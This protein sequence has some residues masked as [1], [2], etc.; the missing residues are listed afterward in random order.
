MELNEQ[1]LIA[2]I[3]SGIANTLV[4]KREFL[5]AMTVE[6]K[7]MPDPYY[8][9]GEKGIFARF[10]VPNGCDILNS[11]PFACNIYFEYGKN[12]YILTRLRSYSVKVSEYSKI[13]ELELI[14]Y[15]L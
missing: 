13:Y 6:I 8:G 7:P 14:A 2:T 10:S 12:D 1:E 15:D 11:N 9:H 4:I 3:V 5:T